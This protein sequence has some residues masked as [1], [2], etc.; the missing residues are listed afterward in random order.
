M[1]SPGQ[2]SKFIPS[3]EESTN[4]LQDV[5]SLYYL[6]CWAGPLQTEDL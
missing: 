6:K 2:V 5:D 3:T 4:I 1:G